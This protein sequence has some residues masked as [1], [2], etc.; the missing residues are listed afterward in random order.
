MHFEDYVL[1]S[2][3]SGYLICESITQGPFVH[4]ETKKTIKTQKECNQLR[5]DVKDM[6]RDEK[7]KLLSNIKPMR[8][9]RFALQAY[10]FRLVS[11]C[12]TSK[13][14]WDKLR[15]LYSTDA[16]LEHTTQTL[17]LSEFGE[18]VQRPEE[19]LIATLY[20]YNH[21]LSKMTKHG[22]GREVIEKNVM[23]MNG[24]RSEWKA[25][26]STVKAHTHFKNYSLAKLV[27]ILKLRES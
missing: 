21:I 26:V 22:I 4:T 8:I 9:I 6:P 13:V 18:F 7:D 19:T 10:T 12:G 27:G 15:E 1:G 3:D 5:L 11:S 2:E 20:R 25:V 24:L 17:L 14:I 23:F 16:D